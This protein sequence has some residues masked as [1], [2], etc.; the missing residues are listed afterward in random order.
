[1]YVIVILNTNLLTFY[2][3]RR[4][5]IFPMAKVMGMRGQIGTKISLYAENATI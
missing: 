4:L 1:M 2:C 3:K 5:S